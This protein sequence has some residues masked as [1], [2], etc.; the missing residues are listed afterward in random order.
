MS[1]PILVIGATA[2]VGS[3]VARKLAALGHPVRAVSRSTS[4][5]F[6]WEN[7]ATWLPALAGTQAAYVSYVPDLAAD[8][9]PDVIRRFTEAARAAGVRKLVLISGRGE[10]GAVR[11]ENVVRDSGLDF[12]LV[13]ASWFNQNFSEGY[14]LP[15]VLGGVIALPAGNRVEPFIDVEDIADVAVAALLDERHNGELYEVTGPRLLTFAEAAAELSAA[16]GRPVQYVPITGE[17]FHAAL[18]P[19]VGL[20]YA[21]LLT[22][23]CEETFDGR[24][25]SLADGVQRALGRAPRDFADF[26]RQA[27]AAGAWRIAA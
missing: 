7:E 3:R 8:G 23:I 26:A 9:A 15:A 18:L 24:N 21:D 17:A 27:A 1:H 5:A 13:R 4:P 6:D 25:E 16:S 2:K 14:L 10:A 12:T 22:R 20:F 19:D 11:S